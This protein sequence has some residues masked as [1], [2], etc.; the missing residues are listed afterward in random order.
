MPYL[1]DRVVETLSSLL[2]DVRL[3]IPYDR[4]D[5]VAQCYEYGRVL[6]AD[7]KEDG[8][9]V[10]ARVTRDFAGRVRPYALT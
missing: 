5:L 4:S 9:H 2:I 7:Y 8:I 3:R 10:E 6:K 1:I